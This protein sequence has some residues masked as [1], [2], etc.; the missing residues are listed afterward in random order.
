MGNPSRDRCRGCLILSE[1]I[2]DYGLIGDRRTAALVSA[3]G[4]FAW[5]CWPDFDSQACFASL[6]GD[7]TN[8]S[9]ILAPK[10]SKRSVRRY[11]PGTLVLETTHLQ[12]MG[13]RVAVTDFMPI[14][15]QHSSVVRIV[16]GVAGRS[17]M[18]TCFAPRFDYGNAQPRLEELH[19]RTWT[20]VT[21]PHRLALRSNVPLRCEKGDIAAEWLVEEGKT[22][23]FTLQYSNS[24]LQPI[25]SPIDAEQRRTGNSCVLEGLDFAKRLSRTLPESRRAFD[26]YPERSHERGVRWFCRGADHVSSGEGGRETQLG[27][28]VLLVAG[29]NLID[30]GPDAL[31]IQRRGKEPGW[32][33]SARSVQGDPRALKTL[34]GVT[35]KREHSEWEANWLAGYAGIEAGANWQQGIR[36]T[37][38]GHFRGGDGRALSRPSHGYLSH[39][40][41]ERRGAGTPAIGAPGK[42]MGG[43]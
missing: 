12:F 21:G 40:R 20:A 37:A 36:P 26:T 2:G 11:L 1:A 30:S 22:Y 28:S 43:A 19:D 24:Y 31:R 13:A 17:R 7:E 41:Q 38:T 35:G 3:R 32:S 29:Y 5:L 6:L 34:Y 39:G 14:G 4:R 42:D 9:W 25:P 27:L 23:Y 18:Q 8:G 16:R 33:G 10:A 15:T